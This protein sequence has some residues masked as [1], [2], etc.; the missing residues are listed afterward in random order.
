MAIAPATAP[1][2]TRRQLAGV[3]LGN[4]LEVYDFLVFSFFAVQ[5]GRTFFPADDPTASLLASLAT[6][7]AGFLA[8]PL[9][10]LVLGGLGDRIGRRPAMILAF[11]LIGVASLG[12]ALTPGHA[13]IGTAAPVLA[14]VFRLLQGFALGG[15]IGSSTAFLAEAAPPGRRGRWTC[16][17][18]VGQGL[19][20]VAAGLIGALLAAVM[21]E[22]ALAQWGWRIAMGLGVLTVPIGLALRGSLPETLDAAI[23][24][25]PAPPLSA[26]RDIALFT[27]A[28]ITFGTIATYV[29]NYLPTF[30][31]ATLGLPAST[32]FGATIAVGV[33]ATLGAVLAGE[34]A[35]RLGPRRVMLAGA[36]AVLASAVPGFMLL[37]AMPGM[38][39][40]VAVGFLTRLAV[41]TTLS[42]TLVVAME[43][44]PARVRSGA[45]SL[46]Y[47]GAVTIFG[48]ST[49]VVVA[50]LV[51]A[52]G[53]PL[54]P[55]WYMT[56]ATLVGVAAMATLGRHRRSH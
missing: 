24:A 55:A 35:D 54:M 39:M 5:I 27:F 19:A 37:T 50:W 43:G 20:V 56:A 28:T 40:L 17:Q 51:A 1:R 10:A 48:G 21:N 9:G 33:G 25:G 49:Q 6:F 38:A 14:I 41:A 45:F 16:L 8:R 34:L 4:A 26:Y 36:A 46:L 52:T 22:A 3:T 12:L 11:A 42:T 31:Q 30:A 44:L 15:E 7:G 23:A 47:A 13:A 2:V 18:Y 53:N 32:A 29:T